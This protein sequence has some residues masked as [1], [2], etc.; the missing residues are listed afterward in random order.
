MARALARRLGRAGAVHRRAARAAPRRWPREVGGEA[1]ASNRELAERADV[2]VLAHKPAQLDAVAQ[3]DR[4]QREGASSRSSRA[5]RW[6]S[7][8]AAY[9]DTPVVPRRAEHAGRGAP[10]R[11]R[12]RRPDAP[13]DERAR[14]RRC[15]SCSAA[16]A[17]SSTSPSTL[18]RVAGATGGVGPAYWALLVE[19]RS[20]PPSAAAC[21]R[22]VA[23]TLVDRDDGR[24]RRAAARA[25]LRH[26]RAC[27]AR[28]PR[29]AARP[30]A[31]SPR[32]SAAACGPR[33]P[34]AMDDVVD[35]RDRLRRPPATRSPT[36]SARCSRV[37][38][39]VIIAWI[40]ISFVFA[41]GVRVPVLAAGR[42]RCSTSCATRRARS[43]SIFRRLPLRIGPLDLSPI[44][45]I[46]ALQI[47]GGIVVGLDH[48]A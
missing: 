26:A 22:Q 47:V 41:I 36:S 2:V 16:S 42:T 10:R 35:S 15:T 23:S 21:R 4:R 31:G 44:V 7:S 13:V 34:Q 6:P 9:P 39:I 11:A 48:A 14:A 25:R 27:A 43:C 8:R 19:A 5:R 33:S 1:V 32:S 38:M 37:Y 46:I 29:P 24:H 17:R 20:T 28:S 30:R 3:R 18:M 40:V 12:L 45:A